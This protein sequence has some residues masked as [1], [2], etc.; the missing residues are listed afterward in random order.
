MSLA[1]PGALDFGQSEFTD[2]RKPIEPPEGNIG[3]SDLG[4]GKILIGIGLKSANDVEWRLGPPQHIG[5]M[6]P[7]LLYR[8]ITPSLSNSFLTV[9]PSRICPPLRDADVVA[10]IYSPHARRMQMLHTYQGWV[11]AR[12]ASA[13]QL[14]GYMAAIYRNSTDNSDVGSIWRVTS[15]SRTVKIAAANIGNSV[16]WTKPWHCRFNLNGNQLKAKWWASDAIEPEEWHLIGEDGAYS[17]A[18]LMGFASTTHGAIPDNIW[19]LDW[20]AW[21]PDPDEPA[22]LYPSE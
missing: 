3:A 5:A 18:G 6:S 13:D 15:G 11:V 12:L 20:Y 9:L 22:P 10:R 4:P 21:S 8:P 17:H 2:W 1:V 19:G 7:Q 14:N 16:D